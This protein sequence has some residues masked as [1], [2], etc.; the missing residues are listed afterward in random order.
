MLFWIVNHNMRLV[1][2]DSFPCAGSLL[3]HA[4][5]TGLPVYLY[6]LFHCNIVSSCDLS[7]N[8]RIISNMTFS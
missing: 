8:S 6:P 2:V 5:M 1:C 3:F 4:S 7:D